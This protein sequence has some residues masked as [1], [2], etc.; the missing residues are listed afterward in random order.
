MTEDME[1]LGGVG[2]RE[3]KIRIYYKR[4]ESMFNKKY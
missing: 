3:T 1:V 2:G 4:R